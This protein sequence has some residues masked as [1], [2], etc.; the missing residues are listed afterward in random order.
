MTEISD[1][2]AG[3]VL[4]DPS[5]IALSGISSLFL[6]LFKILN[7]LTAASRVNTYHT[8]QLDDLMRCIWKS[9]FQLVHIHKCLSLVICMATVI[10]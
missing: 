8:Y 9:L 2:Y 10:R 3:I 7:R 6:D 4:Y 5:Q 1:A